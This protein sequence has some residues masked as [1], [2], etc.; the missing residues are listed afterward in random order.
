MPDKKFTK[1]LKLLTLIGQKDTALSGQKK[2]YKRSGSM[3]DDIEN[4]IVLLPDA[5]QTDI[6]MESMQLADDRLYIILHARSEDNVSV[7]MY[8]TTGS[9]EITGAHVLLHGLIHLLDNDQAP[10]QEHLSNPSI[11]AV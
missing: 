3:K 2:N 9:E 4:K 10:Y 11:L 7:R 5:D 8:D 6:A 1:V